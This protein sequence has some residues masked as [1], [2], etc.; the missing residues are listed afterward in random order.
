MLRW[1]QLGGKSLLTRTERVFRFMVLISVG[2]IRFKIT[3]H[4]GLVPSETLCW[5][6]SG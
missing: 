1:L 4:H 5:D 6:K 3:H 2:K